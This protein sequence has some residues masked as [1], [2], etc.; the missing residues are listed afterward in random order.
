MKK[1]LLAFVMLLAIGA[2]CLPTF[3]NPGAEPDGDDNSVDEN[4]ICVDSCGNGT[5]EEIV[6]MGT[7]CPCVESG[8][9]CPQDCVDSNDDLPASDLIH[10][11]FPTDDAVITNPVTVTGEARG[12]WF[13]EASFPVKIYDA[14]NNLLG[15][16][17][18]QAQSDWMTEDFVP[19]TAI[20]NFTPSSTATGTIVLEK[21]NPSGLPENDNS[22]T[23]PVKF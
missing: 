12:Y 19:F 2:G 5:C 3:E 16:G 14:N 22:L 15:T 9:S 21:D 20:V 23:V 7:G 10:V 11:N 18:A 6:C 17:I 1:F 13:F 4:A 8:S